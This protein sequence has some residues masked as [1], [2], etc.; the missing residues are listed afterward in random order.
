MEHR[1]DGGWCRGLGG[2]AVFIALAAA[3]V[4]IGQSEGSGDEDDTGGG[5][6]C[7][8]R[9]TG[10]I[11][12]RGTPLDILLEVD[13]RSD[14]ASAILDIPQ[15]VYAGVP[16]P[17]APAAA[18]C[19]IELPFGLGE[20]GL[21]RREE[22]L[23]GTRELAGEP[24]Q[25]R[26]RPNPRPPLARHEVTFS[27]GGVALAG[28]LVLPPGPQPYPAV[29]LLHGSGKPTRE[30]WG[31]RSWAESFALRGVAALIFDRR[32]SADHAPAPDLATLAA[33]ARAAVSF[34][35][36]RPELDPARVGMSGGSQG[37]WVALA[38][39]EGD[40]DL[41]FL[42]LRSTA[43]VTPAEQEVQ[44]VVETA[45]GRGL[46]EEAVEEARNYL[47]LY[48]YVAHTGRAW[49]EL[50]RAVSAASGEPWGELVDQPRSLEDLEWWHRNH[51]FS[52]HAAAGGVTAPVL[53]LY[54]G[55]DQVVP[56]TENA[57]PMRR[58]LLDAGIA[59]EVRVF[60]GADHRLEV[61]PGRDDDG[62]WQWF[63]IAPGLLDELDDWL[64]LHLGLDNPPAAPP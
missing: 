31:Y 6:G 63:S 37:G 2:L 15:L 24:L 28:T 20:V 46:D 10:V 7:I 21:E 49:P 16:V 43:A 4:S 48:F 51:A 57:E 30:S 22:M 12:W 9:W 58:L 41:A 40:R 47:R 39:A 35:R 3:P 36:G 42:V 27:S 61:P 56:P 45:R 18:G 5:G 33:D 60:P 53:A 17:V 52:P 34:L 54:G 11:D 25:V 38:A 62:R 13:D 44:R 29:V 64:D 14:G 19:S 23:S 1:A 8:G 50:A 26:L 32:G 59:A 55:A